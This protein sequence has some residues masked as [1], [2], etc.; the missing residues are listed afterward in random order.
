MVNFD[1]LIDTHAHLYAK[2]FK[3]DREAMLERARQQGVEQFL[4]P[5]ID[6]HSIAGM[7]ELEAAHPGECFA[8]MGLHP[9]SVKENYEEE[10]AIV[11]EW[12]DQ[13]DFLAVG[14]IGID[15]YWDKTFIKEQQTA[16]LQQLEWALVIDRPI[17][18]H[19]R[20]S[21]DMLIELVQEKQNGNLRGVFH[22]FTGDLIQARKIMDLG[23]YLG[24]GGVLTY[25]NAGLDKTLNNLPLDRIIL[26]TDAPY[27]SP[28]PYRGKRNESSYIHYVAA[29]LALIKELELAAVADITTAN[30]RQLFRLPVT[31]NA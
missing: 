10:L 9:C 30:A 26:E 17:V 31:E 4:L 8:M 21:I 6:Q 2:A 24:I 28:V 15:L 16:F 23:F 7:L 25:K 20:D 12:L 29:K 13:R 22:C 11:K 5:N 19:A 1:M 3:D 18:I 27:L 14:E